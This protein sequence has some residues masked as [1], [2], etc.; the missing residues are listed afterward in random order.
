M[1]KY[2]YLAVAEP[3][4]DGINQTNPTNGFPITNLDLKIASPIST[5][6]NTLGSGDFLTPTRRGEL[7]NPD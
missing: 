7:L 4:Q 1:V 2:N 6:G 5:T 3:D